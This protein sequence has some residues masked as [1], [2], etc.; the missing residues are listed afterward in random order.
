[1]GRDGRDGEVEMKQK[2]IGSFYPGTKP[3]VSLCTTCIRNDEKCTWE[4]REVVKCPRYV[5]GDIGG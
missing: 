2:T 1:M 4:G 3:G 5:E